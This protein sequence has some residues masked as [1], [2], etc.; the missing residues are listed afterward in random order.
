[1][2]LLVALRP[3]DVVVAVAEIA[4]RV[5][6]VGVQ[7][8]IVQ[9]TREIVV[10]GDMRPREARRIVLMQMPQ[11]LGGDAERALERL[12]ESAV[13]VDGADAQEVVQAPL[14]DRQRAVH[15]GLA[16]IEVR[17]EREPVM[18]RLVVQPHRRGGTARTAGHMA[19]ATCIDDRQ[20]S[21]L[22]HRTGKTSEKHSA[23]ALPQTG[24]VEPDVAFVRAN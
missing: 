3:L 11:D 12:L 4:A 19:T 13:H 1:M 9:A 24:L 8:Q 15:V 7:E 2:T 5:L 22:D 16:E 10:V 6:A 14:L 23:Q 18:Q 17:V 21:G 20:P